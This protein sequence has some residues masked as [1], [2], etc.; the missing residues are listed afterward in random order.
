[1]TAALVAIFG[2]FFA[3]GN[4]IHTKPF[5]DSVKFNL[6]LDLRGGSDL[7][8]DVD[9]DYYL[10]E[11][12][13]RTRSIIGKELKK[14]KIGYRNMV[15]K[16]NTISFELRELS[17]TDAVTKSL[18]AID[19]VFTIDNDDGFVSIYIK[20]EKLPE[21]RE[22]L[23]KQSI[24]TIR[25]RIDEKGN[26][27]I[28]LQSIGGNRI[29]LQMPGVTNPE[30]V[31]KLLNTQAKLSFHLMDETTPFLRSKEG[32]VAQNSK[33][34]E[35]FEGGSPIYYVVKND[36]ELLGDSLVDAKAV[37]H[38][39]EAAVSFTLDA[40]GSR[41]FGE[42]TTKYVG[43]PFAIVFDDKVLSAPVIQEPILGG[44]G[45][46]SGNFS[47][48]EAKELA[49][50]LRAGALPAPISVVQER[51]VGASLG[52]D[53]IRD[54]K[55]AA[56]VAV[57]LVVLFMIVKYRFCGFIASVGVL[58]NIAFI[59]AGLSIFNSTL[60][61]PGIAGIVLT[62]GM[63]VDANILIFERIKECLGLGM[64]KAQAFNEG[65]KGSLSTILDSN[66]TTI[67]AGLA[68]YTIGFGPIKGFAITLIL[69]ILTSMFSSII[70]VRVLTSLSF[71]A[72][73]L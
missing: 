64:K 57:L 59:I 66:L 23:K 30:S 42:I 49:L 43:R 58:F 31:K 24:E 17:G 63:S 18:S 1:M 34:I 13:E 35:G 28:S 36:I 10:N 5:L 54:G 22:M 73:N 56:I 38:D 12:I 3:A 19:D 65:F 68:L 11:K 16:D 9:F 50:L 27:E 33:I 72:C 14:S 40:A 53:S 37:I 46:I 7:V 25:R 71:K 15:A 39:V 45:I 20:D 62:I 32:F 21:M 60:T 2:L 8:L 29:S 6:G 41:T 55:F 26:K 70:L 67:V 61:M 69:G 47:L 51:V 48:E 44:S 4:F 52:E